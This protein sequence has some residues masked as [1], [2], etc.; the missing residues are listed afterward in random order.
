LVRVEAGGSLLKST[1]AA[2]NEIT[3]NSP[4]KTKEVFEM[5]FI[6]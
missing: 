4:A 1:S 5:V 2:F 3:P 6:N